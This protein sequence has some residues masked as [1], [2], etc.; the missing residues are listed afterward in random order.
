[1][2]TIP[3]LIDGPYFA[4]NVL[5][6][7]WIDCAL[8][9]GR[10]CVGGWSAGPIPWPRRFKTG[11]H[12]LILC[13]DLIRAVQTESELAVAYWWDVGIVT[14]WAWR[15]ALGVG[16]MTE[17]TRALYREVMPAKL[18]PE[19]AARGREAARQPEAIAKMAASQRRRLHRSPPP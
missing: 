17:G 3:D 8:T 6:G 18:S 10:V 12:S 1:M 2:G 13:G 11:R 5:P 4:P 7:D 19:A 16:R 14:I 15:K 9:G